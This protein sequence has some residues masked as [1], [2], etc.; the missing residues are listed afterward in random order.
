MN[1]NI[2]VLDFLISVL[3]DVLCAGWSVL[4]SDTFKMDFPCA[5]NLC[6]HPAF[7]NRNGEPD[8][9]GS[10]LELAAY[11]FKQIST[12]KNEVVL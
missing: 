11:E 10:Q 12:L 8:E 3:C 6:F 2:I 4:Q 5:Q 9:I 7:Q 1:Q